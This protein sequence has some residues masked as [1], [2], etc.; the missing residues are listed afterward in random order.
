MYSKNDKEKKPPEKA[1]LQTSEENLPRKEKR[2]IHLILRE[3]GSS[4]SREK[5]INF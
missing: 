4:Q 2:N 3:R 5:A 1:H